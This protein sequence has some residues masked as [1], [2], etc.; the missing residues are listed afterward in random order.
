MLIIIINCSRID[1]LSSNLREKTTHLSIQHASC[2]LLHNRDTI[3]ALYILGKKC[4]SA[5]GSNNIVVFQIIIKCDAHAKKKVS[6]YIHFGSF[7]IDVT[8]IN[9]EEEKTKNY[10]SCFQFKSWFNVD[11][12]ERSLS[13]YWTSTLMY[14][15]ATLST[16][17]THNSDHQCMADTEGVQQARAPLYISINYWFL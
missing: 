7:W 9:F 13:H 12:I 2:G 4:H 3:L 1:S 10:D 17:I 15:M 8:Q 11:A 16:Y 6:L 14:F 5:L